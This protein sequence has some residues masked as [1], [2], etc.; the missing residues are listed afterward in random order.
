VSATL[1]RFAL[2]VPLLAL[3]CADAVG[4]QNAAT[5]RTILVVVD[6]LHLDFRDTPRLRTLVG[7]LLRLFVRDVDRAGVITTAGSA[8]RLPPTTDAAAREA[9]VARLVGMALRPTEIFATRETQSPTAELGHRAVTT[10]TTTAR[11][12]DALATDP[13]LAPVHVLFVSTG[14]AVG[15]TPER[16]AM[17]AAARRMNVSLHTIDPRE[18]T[19]TAA[20]ADVSSAAWEAYVT[21]TRESLRDIA[22]ATGGMAVFTMDDLAALQKR[23]AATTG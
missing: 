22:G 18:F 15:Q 17:I 16:E 23:V 10:F 14:L 11:A 7:Q 4:A 3:P 2:L 5:P 19:D 1:R 9:A 20:P 8:S 6:D 12:L 13:G 21:A